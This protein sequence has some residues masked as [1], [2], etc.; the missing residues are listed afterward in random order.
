MLERSEIFIWGE[1][2]PIL[3][4]SYS[5]KG[6]P[7]VREVVDTTIDFLP[8]VLFSLYD[9]KYTLNNLNVFESE[10]RIRIWDSGGYEISPNEDVSSIM[11][12]T[13]KKES[14]DQSLYVETANTILWG[15]RDILVNFDSYPSI[16]QV[17]VDKQ[18]EDALRIY[19]KIPGSYL[20]DVL[21]HVEPKIDP[22]TVAMSVA[23]NI[24]DIDI[25]GFTEKD[26]APTW[27]VG[28]KYIYRIRQALNELGITDL[29]IHLFGCFDPRVNHIFL[30][31]WCRYF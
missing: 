29:P 1:S 20:K 10:D 3:S 12:S 13:P 22:K 30:S 24:E 4:F 5:G 17:G 8:S 18:I 6:F 14:W 2:S 31:C 7:H 26:I 28:V 9:Y 16:Y 27:I 15:K 21:I 25:L 23:A 11:F 19:Q